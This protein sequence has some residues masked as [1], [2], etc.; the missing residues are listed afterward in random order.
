MQAQEETT[1][2]D[3]LFRFWPW[4]EA[5]ARRLAFGAAFVIIAVFVYSFYSYRQS[6][7]ETAAGEALTQADISANGTQLADACLKIAAD[8]AGTIAGERAL[9]RAATVLFTAGKYADAQV[10]FQ[11]FIDANPDNF[12]TPQATLGLAASLDALGKTDQAASAYQ[13]ASSQNTD[14]SVA[15]YAKFSLARIYVTQGKLADAQRLYGDVARNLEG[16]SLGS[17]A[18]LRALDLNAKLPKPPASPA[19]TAA[20]AAGA[21]F[22]LSK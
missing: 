9:L 16:T 21:P 10:Q 5:N 19:T 15:A 14:P 18:G 8:Y 6:Q 12:F 4:I 3:V 22:N 1:A 7:R 13:R 17:E 11:K 20:P 2:T